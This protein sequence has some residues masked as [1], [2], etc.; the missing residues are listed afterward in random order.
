MTLDQ[1]ELATGGL[2]LTATCFFLL[3]KALFRCS[4]AKLSSRITKGGRIKTQKTAS[5]WTEWWTNDATFAKCTWEVR[6]QSSRESRQHSPPAQPASGHG[7]PFLLRL[8][9]SVGVAAGARAPRSTRGAFC[10]AQGVDVLEC[11]SISMGYIITQ[12][13][14]LM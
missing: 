12:G 3:Q 7:E 5:K 10:T 13:C 14:L 4:V 6:I 8:Q 11:F 9:S 2:S 1:A